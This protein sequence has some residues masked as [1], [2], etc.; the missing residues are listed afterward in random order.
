MLCPPFLLS[1]CGQKEHESGKGKRGEASHSSPSAILAEPSPRHVSGAAFGSHLGG[2][3]IG[4]GED[5]SGAAMDTTSRAA[6]IPSLHQTEIN[7]DK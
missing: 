3:R 6:K 5:L 4:G 1:C 2:S 7:W